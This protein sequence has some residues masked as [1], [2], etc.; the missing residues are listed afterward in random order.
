MTATTKTAE[1]LRL[2]LPTRREA[3]RVVGFLSEWMNH[4]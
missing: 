3:G 4:E 2:E 1:D